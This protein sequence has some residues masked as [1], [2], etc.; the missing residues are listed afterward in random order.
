MSKTIKFNNKSY[1][2]NKSAL[3]TATNDIIA[4]LATIAGEGVTLVIGGVRYN[5]DTN[6]LATAASGLEVALGKLSGSE[7]PDIPVEP[8]YPEASEGLA[9]TLKDD[10]T[11]EVYGLGECTDADVVIPAT[12]NGKPVTSIGEFALCERHSL[13][14][15]TIPNSVTSIGHYAL[16]YNS[17]LTSFVVA[18]DNTAYRTID[19]TI[20]SK[21]GTVLV[22][23]PTGKVDTN[24]TIP[25]GVT[26]IGEDAFYCCRNLTSVMIPNSV[27]VIGSS[28][29]SSCEKLT[30]VTIPDSVISIGD[31]AFNYCSGLTSITIGNSVTSIGSSA[32]S[33]CRAL[34][35][36]A[37]PDSVESIGDAAFAGCDNLTSILV[38]EGNSNYCTFD[39]ILYDKQMTRIVSVPNVIFGYVTIPDSVTS[40]GDHAFSYRTGLTNITIGD[41]VTSISNSAFSSC[42]SLTSVIIG[43]G[44]TSI[45]EE[46]FWNCESL[47]SIAFEGTV[48]QWNAI[49]KDYGWHF[50]VPATYVQCSD[51]QVSLV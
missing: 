26:T 19:G 1:N 14:S 10:G 37:I 33:A 15:I 11:Y 22:T 6:K 2:I 25:N 4:H 20:Y 46:A 38:S 27:T 32:F 30:N 41:G 5:V 21:D 3:S 9:F 7:K 40:I 45:G 29:F 34:T 36:V 39:G 16:N 51:G 50:N 13:T 35:S 49:T 12:Y 17:Y 24:L 42:H 47:T 18:E 28:A 43:N 23:Y 48:A 31:C 8:E 44:V